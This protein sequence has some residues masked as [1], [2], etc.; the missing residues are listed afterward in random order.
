M[1]KL[2][3]QSTFNRF[4]TT[5][6]VSFIALMFLSCSSFLNNHSQEIIKSEND[7]RQYKRI[8]LKNELD[9]LLISDPTTVKAAVAM[10]LYMGSYQN[11]DTRGG[12]AHFLEHMLFLGT[13]Q[14]P[15]AN[16]YQTFISKHGGKHNASTGLEHTNYFFDIDADHLVDAIDR[17]APFFTHPLFDSAYVDRERNAVESEYQLK[18][19]S[20][21][22][23]QWDVLREISNPKH[24]LSKFTVGNLQTLGDTNKS[25]VRDELKSM[26]RQYYSANLMTLAVLG[27]QSIAQ[28]ESLVRDK[29]S[30]INNTEVQI[31]PYHTP[32]IEPS[33][34]PMEVNIK[35]LADIRELSLLFETP[36]LDAYWQTKPAQFLASLVGYEGKGSLLQALKDRGWAESLSAGVALTDRN[37]SLFSIDIGLTPKG[38]GVR[39][40]ILVELFEWLKVIE[41]S[42]IEQWRHQEMAAMAAIEF[43]F[44]EKRD[45]AGYVTDLARRMHH[46]NKNDLLQ[47][48]YDA[49]I[50]NDSIIKD[51]MAKLKLENMLLLVT[52]KET[53]V[54]NTS[55]YYETPYLTA[56]IGDKRIS[57]LS[58][59]APEFNLFLPEKNPYIPKDLSLIKSSKLKVPETIKIKDGLQLWHLQNVEFGVP[60]AQIIISLGSTLTRDING[61]AAAELYVAYIKDRLNDK[62]YPALMAGLSYNLLAS[63]QGIS[64]V[65]GGYSDNQA[66]LLDVILSEFTRPQWYSA[67]VELIRQ[68]LIREKN[69]AKKDYPF[70]QVIAELYSLIEG[71]STQL[72]QSVA[73]EN[74]D[75]NILQQFAG[76]LLL[77]FDAKVLISGN[78][79][80]NEVDKIA[81]QLNILNFVSSDIQFEVAKLPQADSSHSVMVD[82]GDAV[83]VQYIQGDNATLAERAALSML[84]NMMA[85]PFYNELRTEKQLGYVV[86]T[87]PFHANRV[88][89]ITMIVQSPIASEDELKE[90]FKA[91]NR[92]FEPYIAQLTSNELE[93]HRSALL[94]NVEKMPENLAE[95]N[96]RLSKSLRLGY[97]SF[98]F[99]AKLAKAL[100]ALTITDIQSAY[101][102]LIAKSPRRLWLQTGDNFTAEETIKLQGTPKPVYSFPYSE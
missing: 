32:Y 19:K 58:L 16:E 36:K 52:A 13:K 77:S 96:V 11:P 69:N 65:V 15:A 67:N 86:S 57:H 9:V 75:F 17:F 101:E 68:R 55:K 99:R 53:D 72:E 10:D 85:A 20:D 83:L 50:F 51:V 92:R 82:H 42:G 23:R 44:Q 22:R 79:S 33:K 2:I 90:E 40:Q 64:I 38:Y 21:G 26:Y 41:E 73:L 24:P 62:L 71:K 35:P 31:E 81:M 78:H 84:A 5:V 100:S 45:P 54:K 76:D 88:P 14:Y 27:N 34:L 6:S 56:P 1:I 18:Y 47:A 8:R 66:L 48:P 91:F 93:R 25:N 61:R 29:F 39:D 30:D 3:K 49:S 87:F 46:F 98:D 7:Q 70:R 59:A 94:V 12:L 97:S 63:E 89:G 74:M 102:R 4:I 43:R 80:K 95:L 37:A 28:L 60:K